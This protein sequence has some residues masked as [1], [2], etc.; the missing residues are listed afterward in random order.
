MTMRASSI[1]EQKRFEFDTER[2]CYQVAK[3]LQAAV[4][5]G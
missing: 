5:A 3:Q 1:G 2:I 4:P